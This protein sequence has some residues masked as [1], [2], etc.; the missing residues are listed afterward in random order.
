MPAKTEDIQIPAKVFSYSEPSL[1]YSIWRYKWL[2]LL[3]VDT[4]LVFGSFLLAY[5]L[6]FNADLFIEK[7]SPAGNINQYLK[8]AALLSIVWVFLIWRNGGYEN[9]LNE[10]G[11]TISSLH[12]VVTGGFQALIFLIVISFMYREMLLSRSVYLLSY[13]FGSFA[14]FLLRHFFKTVETGLAAKG[15]AAK[16]VALIGVNEAVLKFAK[17]LKVEWTQGKI[18]G[19]ILWNGNEVENIFKDKLVLG[20][21][22]QIGQIYK[23]SHFDTLIIP[24][25]EH[26]HQLGRDYRDTIMKVINFCEEKNIALYMLAGSYDVAVSQHEV[27]T[28]SGMPLIRLKDAALNPGYAII[29]RIMDIFLSLLVIIIGMPIWITIAVIIKFSTNGSV[30]FTQERIG[31]HGRQFI[32]VKFCTMVNDAEEKLKD[33]IDIEKLDVPGFKI[34]NDPRVTPIGRFLRRTSLDEIPQIINVL[35]GEM[36]IVG[37]RPEMPILVARY[38]PEQRRR[39]KA[40]PGITGYQQIKDRGIPLASGIQYDLYYMKHQGLLFEIYIILKTVEVVLRGKGITH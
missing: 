30:F 35:K 8:G 14:M 21:L 16:R 27:N 9:G 6:C 11:S 18:I 3:L 15:F 17:R 39:L 38:T 22:E 37:P 26:T 13:V 32:I 2:I 40:K 36:S 33:L 19:Y 1:F 28:F 31:L 24:S 4:L 23:N 7:L 25:P 10:T 34:K 5:H 20:Q 12:S 29:K